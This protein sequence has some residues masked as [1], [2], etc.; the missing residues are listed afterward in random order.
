MA[1]NLYVMQANLEVILELAGRL[2]SSDN[3]AM[4]SSCER[5]S[6]TTRATEVYTYMQRK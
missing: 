2:C 6:E 5:L 4:V 1:S 3:R